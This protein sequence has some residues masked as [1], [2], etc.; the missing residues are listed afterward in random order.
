MQTTI[1][2][3]DNYHNCRDEAARGNMNV[4]KVKSQMHSLAFGQAMQ[5]AAEDYQKV[6]DIAICCC[7]HQV[8]PLAPFFFAL[9][10]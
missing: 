9:D 5:A 8:L 1:N 6:R 10:H 7:H 4:E 3:W 2:Y